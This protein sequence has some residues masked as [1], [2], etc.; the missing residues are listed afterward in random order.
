MNKVILAFVLVFAC[1]IAVSQEDGTL[2]L[3]VNGIATLKG[4]LM[5]AVYDSEESFNTDKEPVTVFRKKVDG[6]S[7]TV[8]FRQL[9]PGTYG[10]KLY[11]DKN[12]NGKL[13]SLIV[14]LE[15]YGISNN[16]KLRGAPTFQDAAF[17]VKSGQNSVAITMQGS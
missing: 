7:M 15:P 17:E 9:A 2:T 8:S 11:Q 14:P 1:G 3:T 6:R 10:I 5:I 13:D 16:L 12:E 4:N